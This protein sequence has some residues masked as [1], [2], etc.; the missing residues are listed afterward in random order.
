M[1]SIWSSTYELKAKDHVSSSKSAI[2]LPITHTPKKEQTVRRN[3]LR[4]IFVSSKL[5]NS[6][7]VQCNKL[8]ASDENLNDKD[9]LDMY[10]NQNVELLASPEQKSKQFACTGN[11]RS[12]DLTS[13]NPF[14]R[15]VSDLKTSPSILSS[16]N[17]RK[18]GRN[19]MRIRK[20]IVDENAVVESKYF[21][22]QN[23]EKH[24]ASELENLS[25]V[26]IEDVDVKNANCNIIPDTDS[27]SHANIDDQA[28]RELLETFVNNSLEEINNTSENERPTNFQ[29]DVL[30]KSCFNDTSPTNCKTDKTYVLNDLSTF[31]NSNVQSTDTI[32]DHKSPYNLQNTMFKWPNTENCRVSSPRKLDNFKRPNSR[33]LVS[34]IT[35][36]DEFFQSSIGVQRKKRNRL[37]QC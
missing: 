23:G 13:K 22:Q 16:G 10:S 4:D 21:S 1:T 8:S 14:V 19:L 27:I 25:E 5:H 29:E 34:T 36:I 26:L 2:N 11:E 18:R 7:T 15:R 37:I 12:P 28:S 30:E 20:T 35:R 32:N 3:S 31:S 24:E 9:I 33:N 17:C 6:Q